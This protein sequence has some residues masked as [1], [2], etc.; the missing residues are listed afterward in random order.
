MYLTLD[1]GNTA[2]KAVRFD[3][4]DRPHPLLLPPPD[5]DDWEAGFA[6]L[7]AAHPADTLAAASVVPLRAAAARAAAHRLGRSLFEVSAHV[8]L[9]LRMGYATPHTLGADRLAAAAGGWMGYARAEGRPLVVVDAGTAVTYEVVDAEGTY[10][11]GAI[12]PG[13]VLLLHGLTRGTAQLPDVP[14]ALPPSP[15]GRSTREALQSGILYGFVD[16]VEGMLRR[17]EA[18]L[19]APPLLLVTGGWGGALAEALPRA[20]THRPH[21]VHE[22]ILHLA[23]YRTE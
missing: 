13:P 8:P 21:L 19:T 11:G 1:I 20:V 4:S 10:L 22:G 3:E 16:A 2:V 18:H 23:R 9:P 17:L 15:I 5:G 6:D 12:A 14:L 7:F